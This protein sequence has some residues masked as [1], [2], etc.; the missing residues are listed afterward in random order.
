MRRAGLPTVRA[1][2]GRYAAPTIRPDR[3]SGLVGRISMLE[4]NS[5]TIA[6]GSP[7][8]ITS[9]TE[10][11]SSTTIDTAITAFPEYEPVGI[12][13]RPCMRGGSTANGSA[14][15]RAIAADT[16]AILACFSGTDTPFT[17]FMVVA[18]ASAAPAASCAFFGVG[19]SGVATAR[20]TQFFRQLTSGNLRAQRTDDASAAATTTSALRQIAQRPTVVCWRCT[21]TA[22]SCYLD[23]EGEPS[24]N[25]AAFDVGA[26]TPNRFAWFCRPDSAP[27]TFSDDRLGEWLLYDRAVNDVEVVGVGHWLRQEWGF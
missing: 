9:I 2:N 3:L 20:T 16:P 11:V 6:G 15:N 23:G 22:I 25:Q 8:T 19:D 14:S 26:I 12:N 27:D 21:G 1:A 18:V 13:G 4:P 10:L 5:Y 17:M 24:P 7:D